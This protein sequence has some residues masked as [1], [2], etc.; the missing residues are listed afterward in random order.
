MFATALVIIGVV[1]C[2]IGY[3]IHRLGAASDEVAAANATRYASYLL[4]DEMR[5]SSDDLTR[6]ARTYVVSGDPKRL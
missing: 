3:G 4:A 5:Q 2:M 1:M 6:L